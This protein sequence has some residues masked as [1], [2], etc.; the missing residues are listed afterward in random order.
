METE[1]KHAKSQINFEF[2]AICYPEIKQFSMSY[3][4]CGTNKIDFFSLSKNNALVKYKSD[5]CC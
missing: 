2:T 5:N 1:E 4:M 3:L